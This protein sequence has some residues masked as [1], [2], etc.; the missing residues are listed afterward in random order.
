MMNYIRILYQSI[1]M[2]FMV[3]TS[4]FSQTIDISIDVISKQHSPDH[5]GGVEVDLEYVVNGKT[6]KDVVVTYVDY[7]QDH[8]LEKQYSNVTP[9]SFK[10]DDINVFFTRNEGL[11]QVKLECAEYKWLNYNKN[12]KLVKIK[13]DLHVNY[14]SNNCWVTFV[15]DS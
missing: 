3:I 6:T 5:V 4:T 13:A 8:K 2:F 9:G 11:K 7:I 10:L 1:I 12:S 15:V 14:T